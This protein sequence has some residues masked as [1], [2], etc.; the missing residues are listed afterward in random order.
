MYQ[1]RNFLTDSRFLSFIGVPLSL[2]FF[3]WGQNAPD[4]H[5]L[6][7]MASLANPDPGE[8]C[9]STAAESPARPGAIGSMLDGRRIRQSG[10]A[11]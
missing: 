4:S 5:A 1:L 7:A 11:A 8:A 3:F 6:A 9:G 10:A 2:A